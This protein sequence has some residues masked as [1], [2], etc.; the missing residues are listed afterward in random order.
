MNHPLICLV[1]FRLFGVSGGL[2]LLDWYF[3]L[4]WINLAAGN[5]GEV[6]QTKT[7][8]KTMDISKNHAH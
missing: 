3:G 6:R 1:L 7:P 2:M 4:A 8:Q 5:P